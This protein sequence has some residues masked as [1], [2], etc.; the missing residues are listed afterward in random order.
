MVKAASAAAPARNICRG[1]AKQPCFFKKLK[2]KNNLQVLSI[3]GG[4]ASDL[5]LTYI[6]SFKKLR[7]LKLENITITTKGL[8]SLAAL[9]KLEYLCLK[10]I[11]LG[12][13][14]MNVLVTLPALNELEIDT[15]SWS[16]PNRAILDRLMRSKDIKLRQTC[17]RRRSEN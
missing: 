3:D 16:V 4:D 17:P 15:G 9:P 2:E 1:H 14:C 6:A 10:G 8:Q 13:E 7:R 5:S 11:K 12:P